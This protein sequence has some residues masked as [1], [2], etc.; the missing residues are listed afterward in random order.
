MRLK[1][2]A[3]PKVGSCTYIKENKMLIAEIGKNASGVIRV[4]ITGFNDHRF[5]DCRVYYQD[6]S[7]EWKPTKKGIALNE[8]TIDGVIKALEE[9]KEQM[10]HVSGNA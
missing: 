1:A 3:A 4:S 2:R 9:A 8:G 7:G 6:D 10:R 5:I